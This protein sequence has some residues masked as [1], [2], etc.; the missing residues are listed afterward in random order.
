MMMM[1]MM[2]MTTTITT[3]I[4]YKA[5]RQ[6]ANLFCN[7]A[8]LLELLQRTCMKIVSAMTV[9]YIQNLQYKQTPINEQTL[10]NSQVRM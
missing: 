4:D 1:I 3:V 7:N 9:C 8:N 6:T 5:H 2:M 10:N